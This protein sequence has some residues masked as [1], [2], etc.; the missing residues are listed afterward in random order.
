MGTDKHRKLLERLQ[1]HESKHIHGS[2]HSGIG[3]NR[4]NIR[5]R[6]P[7][8][9]ED[10]QETGG[11]INAFDGIDATWVNGRETQDGRPSA[12]VCRGTTCSLPITQPE[13]LQA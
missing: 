11:E 5:M 8:I 1:R 4:H 9:G 12:Y 3:P 13:E 6:H 2:L 7:E 10:S